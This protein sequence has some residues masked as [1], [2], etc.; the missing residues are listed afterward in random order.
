MQ[1]IYIIKN[2]IN[3]YVYIGQS[4]DIAKRWQ[5][6]RGLGKKDCNPNRLEYNNQIHTAMRKLGRE[7]FYVEI[8]E[9]CEKE[10]LNE[11]EIYW[12]QYYNSYKEGYNGTEGGSFEE[13]DT[14]GEKNGRALLTEEDVFYIRE[15]YNNHIPF[16]EVYKIYQD[17]ISKRGLQ[18]I[19]WF[20]T[21]KHIHPEYATLENKEWHKTKAKANSSKVAANNKRSFSREEI[22]KMRQMFQDGISVQEIW[23][24]L[25]PNKA[26]STVYNAIKGITYKD[27]Q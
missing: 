27:I 19:W 17:K 5:T 2:T 25:Y 23:K 13:V 24:Q 16:R 4:V 6:H 15:C 12:I 10:K 20:D 8:L 14:I 7:N 22:L 11:R 18:K 3:N 21:W 26:K 1:G 9:E